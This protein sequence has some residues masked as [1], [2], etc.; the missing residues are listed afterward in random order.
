MCSQLG[1]RGDSIDKSKRGIADAT[2]MPSGIDGDTDFVSWCLARQAIEANIARRHL[3]DGRD[4]ARSIAVG[5]ALREPCLVFLRCRRRRLP[6]TIRRSFPGL[7]RRRA[8]PAPR[9]KTDAVHEAN[10][11]E[12]ERWHDTRLEH[13]EIDA[14]QPRSET[15]HDNAPGSETLLAG[16]IALPLRLPQCRW[17]PHDTAL[18]RSK[19]IVHATNIGVKK[20]QNTT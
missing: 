9:I 4:D 17:S 2:P 6:R 20:R 3:V 10:I 5:R 16:K 11:A 15:L 8:D 14:P 1:S 7:L 18:K 19:S 13:A 12:E